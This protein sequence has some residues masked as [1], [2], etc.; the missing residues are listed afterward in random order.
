MAEKEQRHG[1]TGNRKTHILDDG[2]RSLMNK[3]AEQD[4]A[5]NALA[6]AVEKAIKAGIDIEKIA[7]KVR[8]DIEQSGRDRIPEISTIPYPEWMQWEGPVGLE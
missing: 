7:S 2:D 6:E 5:E 1:L 3:F 8:T 4:Q